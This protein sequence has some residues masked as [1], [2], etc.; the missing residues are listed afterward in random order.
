MYEYHRKRKKKNPPFKKDGGFLE[1]GEFCLMRIF[2]K[3]FNTS[4]IF[5][6]PNHQI[7]Y[8]ILNQDP[9]DCIL[10]Y[11]ISPLSPSSLNKKED[12]S[13]FF[14]EKELRALLF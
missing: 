10:I 11:C 7:Y 1:I 5:M 9:P 12:N 6:I 2:R 3:T 14:L 13:H 8:P 4:Y